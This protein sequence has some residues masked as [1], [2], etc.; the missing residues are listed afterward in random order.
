MCESILLYQMFI[1]LDSMKFWALFLLFKIPS[2][3]T[4]ELNLASDFG[5]CRV[6]ALGAGEGCTERN[7]GSII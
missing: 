2:M 3:Q 1:L 5:K 6:T 4:S 7:E